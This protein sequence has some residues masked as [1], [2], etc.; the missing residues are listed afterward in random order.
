MASEA[1]EVSGHRP[2][3]R[4]RSGRRRQSTVSISPRLVELVD[5]QRV[6]EFVGDDEQRPVVG[7][8]RQIVM[9]D[10]PGTRSRL[11]RAQHRA[12]LDQ[13]DVRR[14]GRRRASPAARPRP[15]CR[16]PGR[17]RH[18]ARRPGRPAR[19]QRSA[20]Q[21]PTSSPNIWLISGAVA[22]SPAAPNGSRVA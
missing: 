10:A 18:N 13:L 4:A 19:S 3:R 17:A 6:E 2:R 21:S 20:S 8:G 9:P 11:R 12:G 5:R 15:A 22:K 14:R 7:Q 1:G 16:G